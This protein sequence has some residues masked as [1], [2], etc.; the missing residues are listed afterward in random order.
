MKSSA[1]SLVV[2]LGCVAL[3][4]SACAGGSG[5]A[6][7]VEDMPGMTMCS[8]TIAPLPSAS[9]GGSGNVARPEVRVQTAVGHT[10]GSGL[11]APRE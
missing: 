9:Q 11:D 10:L 8:F 4:L 1:P 3:T 5:K 6:G 7:C 2:V